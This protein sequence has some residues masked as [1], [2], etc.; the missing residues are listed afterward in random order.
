MQIALIDLIR[1]LISQMM[2]KVMFFGHLFCFH[3]DVF[4]FATKMHDIASYIY[5]KITENKNSKY[6][7]FLL[8]HKNYTQKKDR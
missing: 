8:I 5:R 1:M 7:F 2:N 3:C 4:L 6:S